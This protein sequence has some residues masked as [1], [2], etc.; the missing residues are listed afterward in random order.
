M[1]SLA[2][3]AVD[4]ALS[5]LAAFEDLP[6][7]ISLAELAE[8]TGFHKSTL[9][10]LMISLQEFGYLVRLPDGRY[11]L[12]ATPF[13]LGAIYQRTNDLH[14]R[15]M[16]LLRRL[17][18]DGSESSSYHVR[19]DAE[20]RVCVFRVD[21]PHSTIDR[22]DA[23]MLLPLER[24]AAGRVILAFEGQKGRS[25]DLIRQL[26]L[27]ESFGE[28][29]ADCAALSCPVFGPK[30]NCA[31]AI[32]LSGPKPRFTR[33]RI[34]AM[35]PLLLDAAIRLTRSLG[36]PTLLLEAAARRDAVTCIER[37]RKS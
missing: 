14:D 35:S 5:I 15:T 28:C 9:L 24:G 10:R 27:A 23:G 37:Q 3:A 33:E 8:L 31:G 12:G 6:G 16:P 11:H 18:A 36:G 26:C 30:G 29:G 20:R 17:V 7:P 22:V 21:S 2:V 13:R 32:S 34:N 4:R 1:S 25:Y 19:Y